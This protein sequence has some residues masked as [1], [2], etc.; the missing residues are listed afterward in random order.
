MLPMVPPTRAQMCSFALVF[1]YSTH[2]LKGTDDSSLSCDIQE[3]NPEETITITGIANANKTA[4]QVQVQIQSLRNPWS[5]E[6]FGPMKF[7]LV[8]ADE[9]SQACTGIYSSVTQPNTLQNI[10]FTISTLS[11]ST[12]NSGI[13]MIFINRNPYPKPDNRFK[14]T[15]PES[16]SLS[17][18]GTTTI[19]SQST[20]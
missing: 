4:T 18:T 11:I 15:F 9:L 16:I 10:L 2:L 13:R 8:V 5:L 6:S 7:E 3:V 17:Y 1:R 19:F 14:V 12:T 20:T